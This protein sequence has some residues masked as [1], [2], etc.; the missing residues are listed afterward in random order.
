MNKS[1]ASLAQHCCVVCG[2]NYDTGE[3][4]LDRRLRPRFEHATL[5]GYGLCPEHQKMK[6]DGFVALIECDA[7]R[8]ERGTVDGQERVLKPED[9]CRTGN[10]VFM[11]SEDFAHLF[12]VEVPSQGL[13]YIDQETY[14]AVAKHVP[15][16]AEETGK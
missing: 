15:E 6:D 12:N 13:A 7:S 3:I 11:K 10:V 9:A 14:A 16:Q 2:V 1:Y 8:T 5:V 4:L